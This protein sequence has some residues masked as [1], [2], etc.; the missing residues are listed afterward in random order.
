MKTISNI[1]LYLSIVGFSIVAVAAATQLSFNAG[2][3]SPL[4]RYRIDVDNHSM[5]SEQLTN[6]IVRTKGTASKR[7]GTE[8]V[9]ETLV[10]SN[11]RL[12]PFEFSVDDSYVIE[13]SHNK[14]GFLRTVP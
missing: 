2:Q 1:L 13:L 9:D 5:A 10:K 8:F 12:I 11:V 7:P 14:I 4:M 6:I 3:Q